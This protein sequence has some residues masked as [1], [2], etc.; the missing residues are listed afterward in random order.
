M[1]DLIARIA[2]SAGIEPDVARQA[3]GAILAFLRKE[4]P[5]AEIDELFAALPG[6]AEEAAA[7]ENA[8]GSL[9]GLMSK[10]GGGLMGLVTRL[11]GLGL[12]M[13]Q[14]YTIGHELF[15]YVR[16]LTGDERL[17]RVASAIPGLSQFL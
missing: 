3:V 10:M 13:G 12:S 7:P 2:A 8:G 16:D 11:S 5:K 9:S 14:M 17:E 1:E 6:A 4:G 15:A